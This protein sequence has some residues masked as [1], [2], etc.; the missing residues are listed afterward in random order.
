MMKALNPDVKGHKRTE[1][2]T[3]W[4]RLFERLEIVRSLQLIVCPESREHTNESLLSPFYK[5]LMRICEHFSNGISFFDSETI[6]RF[7]IDVVARAWHKREK[8]SFNFDPK[9]ISHGDFHG[10]QDRIQ[11]SVN[12]SCSDFV[13]G[14]RQERD[15][16]HEGIAE[17]FARWQKERKSFDEVYQEEVRA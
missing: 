1:E 10:W 6:R 16:A 11:I 4:T 15:K 2:Q 9:K 12:L 5:V 13:E 7:Q 14:I 8:A 17:I 3:F